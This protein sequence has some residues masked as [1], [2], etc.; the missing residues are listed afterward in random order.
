MNTQSDLGDMAPL[1]IHMETADKL[2][3]CETG[4]VENLPVWWA[5][6]STIVLFS[7][8]VFEYRISSDSCVKYRR[9]ISVSSALKSCH[10]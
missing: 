6:W 3:D 10:V 1:K 2:A 7:Q 4:K 9:P 8:G 5:N